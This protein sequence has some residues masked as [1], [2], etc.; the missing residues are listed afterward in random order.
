MKSFMS[1]AAL[2][3]S[4]P[5]ALAAPTGQDLKEVDIV[6]QRLKGTAEID[7]AVV[8]KE[9]SEVLGYACSEKLDS[10]VFAKFPVSADINEYGAGTITL[11]STTYKVHEDPSVSGGVSCTKMYDAQEIF[12]TCSAT[13]PASLQL[14]PISARDKKDCFQSGSSPFLKTIASSMSAGISTTNITE[15]S[16]EESPRSLEERQGACGIWSSYTRLKGDGDPHQNYFLKQLSVSLDLA[17]DF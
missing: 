6:I 1:I 7:V 11:G 16:V 8:D 13:V 2:A 12:V 14:A 4:I 3:A 15:R 5:A 17:S 10:G 9:S